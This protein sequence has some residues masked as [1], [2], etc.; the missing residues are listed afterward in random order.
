MG[1][2]RRHI[3]LRILKRL[4][5]RADVVVVLGEAGG[6]HLRR[7]TED[8]RNP[9][10]QEIRRTYAGPGGSDHAV[11]GADHIGHE[12]IADDGTVM[13]YLEQRC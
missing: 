9:T 11:D 4:I 1:A 5:H 6:S 8:E 3:D 2:R 12:F 7:I 13:L 10:W